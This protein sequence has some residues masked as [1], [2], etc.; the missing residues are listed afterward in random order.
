MKNNNLFW[1][2]CCLY[3][4]IMIMFFSIKDIVLDIKKDILKYEKIQ[5]DSIAETSFRQGYCKGLQDL[6]HGTFNVDKNVDSF[7]NWRRK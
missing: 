5:V 6:T 1:G 3:I 2:I 4:A 7:K